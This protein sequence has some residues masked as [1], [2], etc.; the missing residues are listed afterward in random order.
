MIDKT[1]T[2]YPP[3]DSPTVNQP[4][5]KADTSFLV[6]LTPKATFEVENDGKKAKRDALDGDDEDRM[7]NWATPA[8]TG[9]EMLEVVMQLLIS[10]KRRLE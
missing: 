2:P 10:I 9:R 6:V 8:L 5:G 7:R 1:I 3:M 4:S